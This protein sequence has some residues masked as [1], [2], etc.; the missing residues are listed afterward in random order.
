VPAWQYGS[1]SLPE[2]FTA[3][4]AAS[5]ASAL[6]AVPD[7]GRRAETMLDV[8]GAIAKVAELAGGL[9][10]ERELAAK[11]PR[12]A[13]H[14]TSGRAGTSFRTS[15]VLTLA[16]LGASLLER[17]RLSSLL[18]LGG[19]LALRFAGTAAGRA[20]ALDPRATFESQRSP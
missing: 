6:E 1:L 18:E 4:A 2:L 19:A 9:L 10:Y 20:S 5:A 13:K 17:R 11:S 3:S 7:P 12:L 16:S 8:V 14:L 15:Q